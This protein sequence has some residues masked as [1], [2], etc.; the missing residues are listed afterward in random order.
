MQP[1]HIR[2]HIKEGDIAGFILKS[3]SGYNNLLTDTITPFCCDEQ[4]VISVKGLSL[5]NGYMFIEL[6]ENDTNYDCL[7]FDIPVESIF[8]VN[9]H[10]LGFIREDF[11]EEHII[12]I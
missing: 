10:S 7:T 3:N 9:D 11:K 4:I 5:K 8:L 2:N 1:S 12:A 6:A